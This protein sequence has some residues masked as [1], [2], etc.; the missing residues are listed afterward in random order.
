M[1]TVAGFDL[2]EFDNMM[3]KFERL[4]EKSIKDGKKIVNKAAHIVLEQQ[5]QDAPRRTGKGADNLKIT[6]TRLYKTAVYA[7]IG[8]NSKNWEVTK[9]L[10]FQHFGYHN[11]GMGGRFGGKFV[12]VHAGWMNVSFDKCKDRAYSVMYD[13]IRKLDLKL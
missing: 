13:E 11:N 8:I 6:E 3:Q 12:A 7:K 2:K 10:W 1:T 5:R 4:R 9:G